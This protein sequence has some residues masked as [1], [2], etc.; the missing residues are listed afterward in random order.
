MV[1]LSAARSKKWSNLG[2]RLDR[3]EEWR[4]SYAGTPDRRKRHRLQRASGRLSN[5]VGKHGK[6]GSANLPI[7]SHVSQ[8]QVAEAGPTPILSLLYPG[9]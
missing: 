3:Q 1:A 4:R 5:L 6:P 2:A 9:A 7:P 8:Q